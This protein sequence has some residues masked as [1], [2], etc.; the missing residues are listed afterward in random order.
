MEVSRSARE[1]ESSALSVEYPDTVR[2]STASTPY[3]RT[4]LSAAQAH[5]LGAIVGSH[6]E[7]FA[8]TV[9]YDLYAPGV[10]VRFSWCG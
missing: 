4:L 9:L 3:T 2:R 10:P 5:A 6:A 1:R 7:T 8:L